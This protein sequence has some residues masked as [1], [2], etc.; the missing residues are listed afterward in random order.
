ML[1]VYRSK[2][3]NII[4]FFFFF[5]FSISTVINI[6]TKG[7]VS[8]FSLYARPQ[9]K[10][11]RIKSSR[12]PYWCV[13]MSSNVFP[14]FNLICYHFV[15]WYSIS[16]T[17]RHTYWCIIRSATFVLIQWSRRTSCSGISYWRYQYSSERSLSRTLQT[18]IVI[19]QFT[20]IDLIVSKKWIDLSR[21]S[22]LCYSVIL[23]TLLMH[24]FMQFFV[25]N[26]YFF[27]LEPHV[28]TKRKLL[29]K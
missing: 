8:F 29:L 4:L 12:E 2:I 5:F 17:N 1:C 7:K 20:S 26:N 18:S 3:M 23:F 25:D 11:T 28:R 10:K 21:E 6:R 9:G 24:S 27:L 22:F 16:W 19:E 15:L 14:I 13:S